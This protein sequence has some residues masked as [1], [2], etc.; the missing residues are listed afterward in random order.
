MGTCNLDDLS[1]AVIGRASS[2]SI[3]SA[4]MRI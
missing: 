4:V 2:Q 1:V 3:G